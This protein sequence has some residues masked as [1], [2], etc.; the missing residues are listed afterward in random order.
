M[1]FR[2]PIFTACDCGTLLKQIKEFLSNAPPGASE[3]AVM[4]FQSIKKLL[5]ASCSCLEEGMLT[6]LDARLSRPP[7]DLQPRYLAFVRRAVKKMF[8]K[9][10]DSSYGSFCEV[11][12][13]PLSG[14]CSRKPANNDGEYEEG[15]AAGARQSGGCLGALSSLGQAAYLDS[16][17]T[18]KGIETSSIKAEALVVQSAGKPRPLTKFSADAFYLQPLHKTL[19]GYLSQRRWLLR[20]DVET[21][22]ISRA[23]FSADIDGVLTSGDYKSATDNLPIEVAELIVEVIRESSVACPSQVWDYARRIL[24]PDVFY[25]DETKWFV[26]TVGQMMGSYLSFPLLCLQ[27]FLAFKYAELTFRGE[28]QFFCK[29][30]ETRIPLLVNGDDILFQSC[31]EFSAH[32]MGHVGDLGLEVERSKTQVSEKY[33]TIN[34]TLLKWRG[35]DLIVVPTLHLGMLRKPEVPHN[36]GAT[37]RDFLRGSSKEKRFATAC[38]FFRWH[39]NYLSTLPWSLSQLDCRGPLVVKALHRVG[40]WRRELAICSRASGVVELPEPV[41]P[42]NLKVPS[43]DLMMIDA[44]FM[45]GDLLALQSREMAAVKW[46]LARDLKVNGRKAIRKE[47]QRRL[48]KAN[49]HAAATPS[50]VLPFRTLHAVVRGSGFGLGALVSPPSF[51]EVQE[52]ARALFRNVPKEKKVV[53][54][55]RVV[56]ETIYAAQ[57][58]L[59]TYSEVAREGE[60]GDLPP[61]FTRGDAEGYNDVATLGIGVNRYFDSMD[62][63]PWEHTPAGV[64]AAGETVDW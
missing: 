16:V 38:A 40:L 36:M 32:W 47:W 61:N 20:G 7:R 13:P 57:D 15:D 37:F 60:I 48:A 25:D 41:E 27:N 18:G 29:G 52:S 34:S 42:H 1:G 3:E 28:K 58:Y 30:W 50:S 55:L 2:L 46:K 49:N 39:K 5:P 17:L 53:P 9:G 24:R 4:A 64:G 44:E 56:V 21:G 6:D 33:G 59:P 22:K 45:T 23:G 26:P 51:S 35:N 54:A 31:R 14:V 10:W 11:A 19:Y 12:A 43:E 8:P 62:V 63:D